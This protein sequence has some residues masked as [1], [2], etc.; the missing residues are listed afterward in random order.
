MKNNKISYFKDECRKLISACGCTTSL[1]KH[2]EHL[3][4]SKNDRGGQ[5][6]QGKEWHRQMHRVG[7][8]HSLLQQRGAS[9]RRAKTQA[10]FFQSTIL[11]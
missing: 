8:I 5:K 1:V 10:T 6:K 9:I 11:P 7:N 3:S 4:N 2:R